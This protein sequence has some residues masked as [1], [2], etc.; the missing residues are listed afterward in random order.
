MAQSVRALVSAITAE[1]EGATDQDWSGGP[2]YTRD[3]TRDSQG[4]ISGCR[5]GHGLE[6]FPTEA[7]SAR[8]VDK[9]PQVSPLARASI[10]FSL[11]RTNSLVPAAG[12]RPATPRSGG[13]LTDLHRCMRAA[14][15]HPPRPSAGDILGTLALGD[16]FASDAPLQLCQLGLAAHMQVCVES[17]E[18]AHK[19][20][21]AGR[22]QIGA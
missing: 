17:I 6:K 2:H 11:P 19:T 20:A 21:R 15:V 8:L 18:V 7:V 4:R 16:A 22:T 1:I 3:E 13:S 9:G 14:M 10:T 5:E 12:C